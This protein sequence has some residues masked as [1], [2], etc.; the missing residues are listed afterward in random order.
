MKRK[1]IICYKCGKKGY[2]KKGFKKIN[3]SM[4]C[5]ECDSFHCESCK[6]LLENSEE[7]INGFCSEC[8]DQ[9]MLYIYGKELANSIQTLKKKEKLLVAIIKGK[10]IWTFQDKQIYN[11][12]IDSIKKQN[13]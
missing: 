8:N 4:L 7:R 5:N 1:Q 3:Q 9:R 10:S 13:K 6:I 11:K 2:S 12:V